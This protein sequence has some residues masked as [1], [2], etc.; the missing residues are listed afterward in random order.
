MRHSNL[1]NTT[2]STRNKHVR[3]QNK[4]SN[5]SGGYADISNKP[6]S[7]ND[8]NYR[9][10]VKSFNLNQDINLK[11]ED[12]KEYPSDKKGESK[13]QSDLKTQSR[14]LKKPVTSTKVVA[15]PRQQN[16]VK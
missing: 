4:S 2:T 6:S 3:P 10:N 9:V 11:A 15:S 12:F 5:I 7:K 16:Q 14:K 1:H 8:G 13:C